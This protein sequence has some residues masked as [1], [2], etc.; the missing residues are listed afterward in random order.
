LEQAKNI[1]PV[2][3]KFI[4]GSLGL[5]IIRQLHF[6]LFTLEPETD[7]QKLGVLQKLGHRQH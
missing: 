6:E 1:V 3:T 4:N 5:G 7:A 2:G